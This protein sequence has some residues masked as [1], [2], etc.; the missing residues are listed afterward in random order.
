MLL[1]SALVSLPLYTNGLCGILTV[2]PWRLPDNST[3]VLCLVGEMVQ[4]KLLPQPELS[5]LSAAGF[6]GRL[7]EDHSVGCG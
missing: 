2:F 5:L 7:W 3:C 6:R 1:L 4:G